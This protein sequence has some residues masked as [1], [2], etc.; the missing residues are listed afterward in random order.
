MQSENLGFEPAHNLL[1]GMDIELGSGD[2]VSERFLETLA[3]DLLPADFLIPGQEAVP[4]PGAPETTPQSSVQQ[5]AQCWGPVLTGCDASA[6]EGFRSGKGHFKN[7]FCKRCSEGLI[8]PM[9][10]VRALTPDMHRYFEKNQHTTGLWKHMEEQFGGG[11]M[12]LANN[13]IQCDGPWLVVFRTLPPE[14][15]N[16]WAPIPAEWI[17]EDSIRFVVARGTLVPAVEMSMARKSDRGDATGLPKRQRRASNHRSTAATSDLSEAEASGSWSTRPGSAADTSSFV[18]GLYDSADGRDSVASQAS[19][20]AECRDSVASQASQAS[21]RASSDSSTTCNTTFPELTQPLGAGLGGGSS[22]PLFHPSHPAMLSTASRGVSTLA[23]A[24]HLGR[25][26]H[27]NYTRLASLLED[28]LLQGSPVRLQLSEA[29]TSR[30]FHQLHAARTCLREAQLLVDGDIPPAEQPDEVEMDDDIDDEVDAGEASA[31]RRRPVPI[32][33]QKTAHPEPHASLT[34]QRS[35]SGPAKLNI[36]QQMAGLRRSGRDS[37]L[38]SNWLTRFRD[39]RTSRMSEISRPER[40]L[41]PERQLER[42]R[43]DPSQIPSP[44]VAPTPTEPTVP[45]K[46]VRARS[47]SRI[48]SKKG[49]LH[50]LRRMLAGMSMGSVRRRKPSA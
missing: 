38:S 5:A 22:R 16:G 2:D 8:V 40:R 26:L 28:A 50:A 13:T 4:T 1:D 35:N 32:W 25:E 14:L 12:R 41:Q 36:F 47:D 23:S 43:E 31:A 10:R 46:P 21:R 9:V 3:E 30:L 19:Q 24:E 20:A 48:N 37:R 34:K 42:G 39:S 44:N 6:C 45:V 7:K 11:D 15:P 17:E 33:A 27:A 29:Q 18:D 49:S